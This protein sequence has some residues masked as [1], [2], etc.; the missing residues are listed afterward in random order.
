MNYLQRMAIHVPF[1]PTRLRLDPIWLIAIPSGLWLLA[2]QILPISVPSL[3]PT[4]HWI[5]AVA[6]GMILL[7][8]LLGHAA[9]HLLAARLTQAPIPEVL[10][11]DLFGDPAQAWPPAST[12]LRDAMVSMA[13][14]VTSGILAGVYALIWN[15]QLHPAVNAVAFLGITTN[16]FL[17]VLNLAPMLPLD[18]GRTLRSI[19]WGDFDRPQLWLPIARWLGVGS[20]LGLAAWG[21]YLISLNARFSLETGAGTL[22]LV[23]V[24]LLGLRHPVAAMPAVEA[25]SPAGLLDRIGGAVVTLTQW[26][27]VASLIPMVDGIYAPGP[28]VTVQPMIVVP[29]ERRSESQGELLLTTVVAQ[30]PITLA[31]R[32]A[33]QFQPAFTIVPPEQV[34][35]RNTT[36]QQMM[37]RNV[38]LLEESEA[39]AMVVGVQ[40]AGFSAA[41]SSTAL[42]VTGVLPE[43]PAN[44]VVQPEDLILSVD[45]VATPRVEVLRSELARRA[46][47]EQVSLQIDRLGEQQTVMVTLMPPAEPGAPPRIG[48]SLQPYGLKVDLPFPVAIET[49]KVSG[50]PSAG[51]MFTLAI[52]DVLTPEDLTKGWRI[53][54]TGTM[55][56]DGTVGPIGGIAQKVAGAEWAGADYFITPREHEQEAQAV[57]RNIKLIVVG[58]V[59]EALA[60]L[61]ALP[62]HP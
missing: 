34:V 27:V 47:G 31:Q 7:L 21:F 17:A 12:P 11:F 52:Y 6:T 46:P 45:G 5:A 56:L 24:V 8:S 22:L 41:L 35:P 3:T 57:A 32:I 1:G 19:I 49:R 18:G 55:A 61:H 38:Q 42:Q 26:L 14:P 30:T 29:A 48:V 25:D 44:G 40:K 15:L 51:L 53:A 39:I 36:P 60:A 58:N 9:G 13:G 37:R 43:S 50:G 59:D 4:Q 20:M 33:A 23:A 62:D 54:G 28:A 10:P 16:T 2:T